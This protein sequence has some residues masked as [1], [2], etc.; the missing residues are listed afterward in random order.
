MS[1]PVA[2]RISQTSMALRVVSTHLSQVQLSRAAIRQP[3]FSQLAAE[4]R[5]ALEVVAI[6]MES[7]LSELTAP[8]WAELPPT[9]R[10]ICEDALPGETP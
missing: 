8:R 7:L 4:L 9:I 10:R 6:G 5:D 3:D 1:K 2:E